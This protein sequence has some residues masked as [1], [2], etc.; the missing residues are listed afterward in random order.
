[1]PIP[2]GGL[3]GKWDPYDPSC[4]NPASPTQLS[5]LVGS[6][7]IPIG[8]SPVFTAVQGSLEFSGSDYAYT[9]QGTRPF[10]N[11]GGSWTISAWIKL[12][13]LTS[14]EFQIFTLG[15]RGTPDLTGFTCSIIT[16]TGQLKYGFLGPPL[17][18]GE[19]RTI[20]PDNYGGLD[21]WNNITCV[22]SYSFGSIVR[23]YV[24]GV[25]KATDLSVITTTTLNGDSRLYYS[26]FPGMTYN[27]DAVFGPMLVYNQAKTATDALDIY[28]EYYTR[29]NTAPP[30]PAY[31][32]IVGGRLF[33]EGF[34]G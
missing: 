30:S 25:Q 28:N 11:F 9:P 7:A 22:G 24:N 4:Y 15:N 29:L 16:S 21:T 23:V 27:N 10:V 3:I 6:I 34:N 20:T 33:G 2:T 5:P 8:G 1:M 26:G 31:Q 13:D 18:P 32:G 12:R 17:S 14:S 19:I